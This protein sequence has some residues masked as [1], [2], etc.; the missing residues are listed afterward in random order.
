MA[1]WAAGWVSRQA[2]PG[3]QAAK[4]FGGRA[5]SSLISFP[6]VCLCVG[7]GAKRSRAGESFQRSLGREKGRNTKS[8]DLKLLLPREVSLHTL[9]AFRHKRTR[10]GTGLEPGGSGAEG[11]E[12]R[13]QQPPTWGGSRTQ[14]SRWPE[15]WVA[16]KTLGD[17]SAC[18]RCVPNG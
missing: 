3:W 14:M 2:A 4:G 12:L 16:D 15:M 13:A 11:P 18:S 7:E 10:A 1:G 5:I 9:L 6:L 8:L 17:L